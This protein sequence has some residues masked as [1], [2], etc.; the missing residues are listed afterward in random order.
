M[1]VETGW[2]SDKWNDRDKQ[3]MEGIGGLCSF[4]IYVGNEKRSSWGGVS[5]FLSAFRFAWESR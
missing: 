3:K 4:V 2:I 5:R 1:G